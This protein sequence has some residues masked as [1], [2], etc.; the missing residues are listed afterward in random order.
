MESLISD[1]SSLVKDGTIIINITSTIEELITPAKISI[2]RA[3]YII[4]ESFMRTEYVEC[5][6]WIRVIS[7]WT[8]EQLHT[9]HWKD[10]SLSYRRLYSFI[11]LLEGL[12]L[13]IKGLYSDALVA[14]D[15]GLLL[16]SPIQDSNYLHIWATALTN[17]LY[18]TEQHSTRHSELISIR[19]ERS[20]Q[21]LPP[22]TKRLRADTPST[23]IERVVCPSLYS[24]RD[25]YMLTATPVIISG[26]MDHWPAMTNRQ[27]R[28]VIIITCLHL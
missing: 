4:K 10:V 5:N 28:Y 9:G 11:S 27:W 18:E 3:I 13:S 17:K 23:P 24:F 26:C 14:I 22:L 8:W 21:P 15:R 7:D 25:D 19:A 1:L 12:V 20:Y 2:L 6:E 16:G